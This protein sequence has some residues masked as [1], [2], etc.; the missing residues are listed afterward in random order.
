MIDMRRYQRW[1]WAG[2]LI[3]II[4]YSLTLQTIPNGSSHYYMID[5]GETQ[6]VLNTWGTL[7]ATGYPLYVILGNSITSALRWAGV[8]A[9]AAP[10]L[11]SMCWGLMALAGLYVLAV[12]LT[13]RRWLSLVAV[14]L[15]GLTRTV[16]IH[17]VIAEIYSFGLL[18]LVGL[19]LLALWREP[20][21]G[22]V[23]WLALLGGIAV[24]HHRAFVTA[25]P[26]LVYATLP[27]FVHIM[28]TKPH[29]S[30]PSPMFGEEGGNQSWRLFKSPLHL[31]K[32]GFRGEVIT[33]LRWNLSSLI[34]LLIRSLLLG[35]VGLIP[36]LYLYL[37]AQ[38]GAAWV[39]GEPGTLAGLWDQ[40]IGRE[41]SRFI[42]LPE[43]LS[44]LGKNLQ[45]VNAVL[46]RDLTVPG[47][48]AGVVGLGAAIF[49]GSGM[50]PCAPAPN[51]LL[52]TRR[53][54]LTL[55]LS[56][57]V[58]YGFHALFYRDVLSAL[59]LPVILSLAFGWLFLACFLM[60]FA[61]CLTPQPPLHHMERGRLAQRGGDEVNNR[62][63]TSMVSW[64]S[65]LLAF[66]SLILAI[67]LIAY[68]YPFI[69]DL[70]A[71]RTGLDSIEQ[72]AG[73]PAGSTLMI[74]WGPRHFAVGFAR[75]VAGDGRLQAVTLVDHKVDFARI[76]QAG[77]LVT[78]DYTFYNQPVSWW[79]A[80]LGTRVFLRAAAPFLVEIS[81]APH[82]VDTDSAG[83]AVVNE[84]LT[85]DN[86][87]IVLGVSWQ[88]G[89]KPPPE[90]MSVFVHALDAD[91]A[92]IAQGD[93][94]APVYGWRP[95]TTWLPGEIVR[96][97]Y[98]V[99][100]GSPGAVAA[101][102]YGLYRVLPE[103]GF[104]NVV[105]RTILAGCGQK[106]ESSQRDI[107]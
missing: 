19:L 14:I 79:E 65:I 46:V 22:R 77:T 53:A 28:L 92:V 16:W 39:Y 81:T 107:S 4:P 99:T 20:V 85:C 15:F 35:L 55:A 9:A 25:I 93:Q 66:T 89:S 70:T 105:E 37:R 1:C 50:P 64:S 11:V 47:I 69:H 44:A 57:L 42:G 34:R 94:F 36:Y 61:P 91:G 60:T 24:A 26:A 38:A 59:I 54:A 12:H 48:I 40:V 49:I 30:P 7:H 45:V 31:L 88:A 62:Y 51:N 68:N 103:G 43:S 100:L 82:V 74:A 80:R 2:I 29:P 27:E 102:R 97:I 71:D 56:A 101:V 32:R 72:A 78:P 73:A 98:P 17:L 41:A 86:G 96:D 58:S 106:R 8:E 23:Y 87:R 90:D 104:D 13:G 21:R 18:L 33:P 52:H 76:V 63:R 83:I 3:L 84:S 75:D 67:Y 10:G 95:L 6:I 5:V